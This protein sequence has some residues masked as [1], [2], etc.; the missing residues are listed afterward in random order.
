[1][2]IINSDVDDGK[3]S[4]LEIDV[5]SVDSMLKEGENW[6]VNSSSVV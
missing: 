1:M 2:L 4:K 5:L 3:W 6:R